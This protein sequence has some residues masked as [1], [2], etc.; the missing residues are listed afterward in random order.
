MFI[1]KTTNL[2]NGKI[3]IGKYQGKLRNYLG[4][5]KIL[6]RSMKKYGKENFVKEIIEDGIEDKKLL[7]EREIY[8]IN[9]YNSRDP[10]IGYNLTKGGEGNSSPKPE[11][12]KRYLSEMNSGSGNPFYGKTHSDET[13]AILS[14][15]SKE[16]GPSSAK[17]RKRSDETKRKISESRRGENNPNYGKS[18][19]EETKQKISIANSGENNGNY[20]KPR[21]DEVKKKI[22]ETNSDGRMANEKN[23][24]Y[25]KKQSD[26]TKRKISIANK[27]KT[28][29]GVKQSDEQK[30]KN[31]E[32]HKGRT[33]WN[34]GKKMTDEEKIKIKNKKIENKKLKD[35]NGH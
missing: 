17:G 13:K 20:G 7:C 18:P 19:S 10:K 11:I 25:G 12:I 30:R 23:G 21:S 14:E 1:Y 8:W 9:F 29:R 34:K 16:G 28:R 33:P 5:G 3:Y 2:I 31:S 24:M 15:K 35:N 22:S 4:S 32:S 6:R 27:G 26:E